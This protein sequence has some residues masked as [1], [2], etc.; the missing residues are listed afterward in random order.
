MGRNFDD[1]NL[2]PPNKVRSEIGKEESPG[3]GNKR[4]REEILTLSLEE[5]HPD[6][7]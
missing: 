5:R 6:E 4:G 1:I 2:L 7:R 3:A